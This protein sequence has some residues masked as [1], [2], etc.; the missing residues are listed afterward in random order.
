MPVEIPIRQDFQTPC[1]ES[2]ELISPDSS[3]HESKILRSVLTDVET[4]VRLHNNEPQF[5][6]IELPMSSEQSRLPSN[7][8]NPDDLSPLELSKFNALDDYEGKSKDKAIRNELEEAD[9]TSQNWTGGNSMSYGIQ[10]DSSPF[11]RDTKEYDN[12][13]DPL[14]VTQEYE[15]EAPYMHRQRSRSVEDE[16][17]SSDEEDEEDLELRSPMI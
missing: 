4:L 2:E 17:S 6:D 5:F 11:A 3:T 9:Q 16:S 1:V 10:L 13:K 7:D 14:L 8:T 15:S 12:L